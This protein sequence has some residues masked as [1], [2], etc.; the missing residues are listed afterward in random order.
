MM[1]GESRARGVGRGSRRGRDR[2]GSGRV[3]PRIGEEPEANVGTEV[4]WMLLFPGQWVS[5]AR[6]VFLSWAGG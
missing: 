6:F 1:T 5:Q 3:L 4:T 2:P